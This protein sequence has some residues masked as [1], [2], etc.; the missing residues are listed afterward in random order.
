MASDKP[1]TP[2]RLGRYRIE[3]E[4]GRGGSGRVYRAL[5]EKLHRLVALKVLSD[6]GSSPR[7]MRNRFRHEA[8]AAAVLN[9]PS[10]AAVYD[11]DEEDGVAFI[12][13]EYVEGETLDQVVARGPLEEGRILALGAALASGLAHAHGRGILHRDIKPQ[14]IVITPGGAPKILDF[15]LAKQTGP[16]LARP[17]GG[18]T[19]STV[20]ETAAGMLVGTVQYMAP[21]QIG[22]EVLD[23]R[24]DIFSLGI[25][26]YELASGRNPFH[27]ATLGSTIGNI[28]SLRPAPLAGSGT[29]ISPELEAVIERCL[30][31]ERAER[32]ATAAELEGA[33]RQIASG[34][35]ITAAPARPA[36]PA[37]I[38][39]G[40]ARVLVVLLQALYLALYANAL[41]YNAQVYS[42]VGV[43][44]AAL[45]GGPYRGTAATLPWA[46][47]FLT[48]ACW[49]IAVRLYLLASVGFDD[50]DTG[51]QFRRLFPV[52]AVLDEI[53]ALSP[54]LMLGRWPEGITLV[55]M[56]LL[57]YLPMT[58]RNLIASAYD[59]GATVLDSTVVPRR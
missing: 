33:L 8:R 11:Y 18:T 50:P 46:T 27:G 22:G 3:G 39:R 20:V 32:F 17:G 10:I 21:E 29:R 56:A 51:R 12:A 34:P 43:G 16:A 41:Y 31:K 36:P 53:W 37:L 42:A 49:G 28:V 23:G 19:Q 30:R 52:L 6:E 7:E 58:H 15:G 55:C 40:A 25:V 24:S 4:L 44:I 48:T 14:N 59:Q 45:H 13:Y 47:A 26:L 57:A 5:D 54:L 1:S 38:P 2:T 35:S 9:H